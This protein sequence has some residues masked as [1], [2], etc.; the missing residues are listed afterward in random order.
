MTI[1][2]IMMHQKGIC[3]DSIINGSQMAGHDLH[4]VIKRTHEEYYLSGYKAM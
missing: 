1:Q 4:D 2:L 3:L